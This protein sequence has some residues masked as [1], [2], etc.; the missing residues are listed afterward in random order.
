MPS[1]EE[2]I[3]TL[4]SVHLFSGLDR[5][6]LRELAAIVQEIE[7][8]PGSLICHQG[9]QGQQYLIIERGGLRA[10]LVNPEGQELEARRLGP[11]EAVGETSL[12]LGDVRDATIESVS[13]T[14]LLYI[15]KSDFDRLLEKTRIEPRLK[16]RPDIAERRRYPRFSWMEARELPV[17]MLHKH[18]AVLVPNLFI[19]LLIGVILVLAGILAAR[20]WHVIFLWVGLVLSLFPLGLALYAYIDW[21]ND[22]YVLT[23]RRIVHREQ[24]GL[25]RERFSAAPLHAV[26]DIQ[27]IQIGMLSHFLNYGDLVIET[28]GGAGQ[29]TFHSVPCPDDVR[30]EIF[31]QIERTRALA[32]AQE[33][34]AIQQAMHRHF[35]GQEY[36]EPPAAPETA[37]VKRKLPGLLVLITSFIPPSWHQE[38]DTIT[39]RK[40]WIALIRTVGGAVLTFI[41]TTTAVLALVIW[42]AELL[43]PLTVVYA[44]AAF[45][46]IPWLLWQFDDWQNDFYQVTIARVI[47]VERK[48]F[49]LSEKRREA[50]LQQVTNVRFE[51]PFWGR[52]FN[53]GDVFVETAAPAGTFH[54]RMASRPREIQS[55][56]FAHIEA[57]RERRQQEDA[58]QR[59]TELLDWFST[60]DE[61]RRRSLYPPPSRQ[62]GDSV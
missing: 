56:I 16:M 7:Y 15:E 33:R 49:F 2:I 62:Q 22:L 24:I 53:Y 4:K 17:K 30:N 37:P 35:L 36:E 23:N 8:A 5:A 44:A 61:I 9:E 14:T 28:A 38:G 19:P 52:I 46:I 1:R 54:F 34:E 13:A 3:R 12:L 11:G 39:W 18:P 60:Y 51:Q 31:G 25:V 20:Q 41:L 21:R 29:V 48:P 58:R 57:S 32:R 55:E 40:H 27:Q 43:A 6:D 26:Q 10:T 42:R 50:S 45:F 59:R 47:H